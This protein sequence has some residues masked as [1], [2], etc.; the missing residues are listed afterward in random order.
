M[1]E[2]EIIEETDTLICRVP[3]ELLR[4]K[5]IGCWDTE[6]WT[7]FGKRIDILEF[8]FFMSDEYD[9]PELICVVYDAAEDIST[10]NA[11]YESYGDMAWR[12]LLDIIRVL[13]SDMHE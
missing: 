6:S 1:S 8:H 2:I 13:T 7:E 4:G 12:D 9:I 3:A 11:V 5:A 10:R